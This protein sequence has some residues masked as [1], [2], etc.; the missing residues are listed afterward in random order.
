MIK[1]TSESF[2]YEDIKKVNEALKKAMTPLED[3]AGYMVMKDGS[4]RMF[5]PIKKRT[6]R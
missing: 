5:G 4:I 2:N 6:K 1:H 3:R